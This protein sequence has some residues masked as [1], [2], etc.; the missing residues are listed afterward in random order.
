MK[1]EQTKDI[2]EI[3][4]VI[5]LLGSIFAALLKISDYSNNNFLSKPMSNIAYILVSFLLSVLIFIFIFLILKSL[6][7]FSRKRNVEIPSFLQFQTS[8][9]CIETVKKLIMEKRLYISITLFIFLCGV[10]YYLGLPLFVIS[11]S[12]SIE[13]FLQ[14]ND[15]N[16]TLIIKETGLMY[17]QNHVLL[18]KMDTIDVDNFWKIDNL[19]I[20]YNNVSNSN[21]TFGSND[22]NVS[23]T[24]L[25]SGNN[26]I[27]YSQK[28][29]M[30]GSTDQ[31]GRWYIN[32]NT[33]NLCSGNYKLQSQVTID[34][35][36]LKTFGTI[37]KFTNKMFYIPPKNKTCFNSSQSS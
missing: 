10:V 16:I 36:E 5:G 30:V 9:S 37:N 25:P 3:V 19:T 24:E 34:E 32:I 11:G 7:L 23:T 29:F 4:V 1:E 33:T 31:A 28:K 22:L 13:E 8:L 26:S 15:D 35:L 2:E 20:I 14:P 12:Y 18:Y 21:S 17:S 27:T 6:L